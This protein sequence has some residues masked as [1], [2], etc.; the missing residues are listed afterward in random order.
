MIALSE[1]PMISISCSRN[2]TCTSLN[3]VNDASSTT[4]STWSSNSTGR[5]TMLTGL[6]SPR[7]EAIRM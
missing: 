1:T 3:G 4:P 6:L 2:C 5:I 7:P